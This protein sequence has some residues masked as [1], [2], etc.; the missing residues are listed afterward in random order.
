MSQKNIGI[1]IHQSVK[2]IEQAGREI[3]SLSKL[4]QL[5]ID[6]AMSSK[7]ST[8]CKIV[9]SWNENLSE[10]YDELEFV[11]T[12]YAFSL[13][14]GQIK[15]GRSTTA[16]WLGVQISLAGDGM[17]SEIVENEQPLVHIN[18]WNHPVYFDEELYMG[19]KIKPV[20]SPDSIVLINNILFDWTPEKALW[21]DKEWTYSLFLT[22]LNTIDD[23]RKKIVQPVTELMKSASPEQAK[24]TEIEG[25]VRYIK[26]D[27]NQYDISNM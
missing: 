1:S 9:E 6:N 21:Q 11:C 13:G 23:I 26:I 19:P 2:M 4:I 15:K 27:E 25:V 7:L 8:V 22:S 20:M 3:D 18:L 24:L 17:C 16:R 5:E 12:G 10:L 14:L